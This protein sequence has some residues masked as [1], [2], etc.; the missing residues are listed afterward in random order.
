VKSAEGLMMDA[1]FSPDDDGHRLRAA[2]DEIRSERM[3]SYLDEDADSLSYIFERLVCA[4]FPLA[5]A[6]M[7][8]EAFIRAVRCEPSVEQVP[9]WKRFLQE[10]GLYLR[11]ERT[12]S[13]SAAETHG[14][15]V[16]RAAESI[17]WQ[18]DAIAREAVRDRGVR[19]S[20]RE[21]LMELLGDVD[22]TALADAIRAERERLARRR[23]DG[24]GQQ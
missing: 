12:E 5:A 3:E 4:G 18:D 17:V 14:W 6:E 10:S 22:G 24:Q 7:W 9:T 1:V 16:Q 20:E 23:K 8:T 13:E 21:L 11:R 15:I 2:I 19:H